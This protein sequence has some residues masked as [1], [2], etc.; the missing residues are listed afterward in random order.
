MPETE[1]HKKYMQKYHQAQETERRAASLRRIIS[2]LSGL[3][4]PDRP[5][6]ISEVRKA[7]HFVRGGNRLE[8]YPEI[9]QLSMRE[10][11]LAID[12]AT[13]HLPTPAG[14]TKRNFELAT[15]GWSVDALIK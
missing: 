12:F 10:A 11:L 3:V 15:K 7:F 1:A 2:D 5:S 8:D 14:W 6:G 9:E 13:G 4:G